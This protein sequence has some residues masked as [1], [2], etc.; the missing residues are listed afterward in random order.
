ML[1]ALQADLAARHIQMRIVEAHARVR[2]LLR[3]KGLEQHVGYFGRRLSVDQAIAEFETEASRDPA[4]PR[5]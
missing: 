1:S 2:D 4:P 5:T 3:A